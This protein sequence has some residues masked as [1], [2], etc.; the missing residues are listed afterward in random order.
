MAAIILLNWQRRTEV[1][2][3][4]VWTPEMEAFWKPFL[5]DDT[6]LMLAYESRLFI[7]APAIQLTVRDYRTNEM[8]EVPNSAALS[9]LQ[10]LV[11]QTS[12]ARTV[13]MSIS[14]R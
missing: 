12:L 13:I 9:R 14:D 4:G 11:D 8:S 1:P 5:A 3:A 6:P 10:R 7:N 2:Q